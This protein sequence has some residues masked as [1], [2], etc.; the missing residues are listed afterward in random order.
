M[1]KTVVIGGWGLTGR[2]IVSFFE[3]EERERDLLVVEE[4]EEPSDLPS[5]VRYS[6]T[7]NSFLWDDAVC[8]ILSPGID[9]Q[10]DCFIE[11]KRRGIPVISDL[12]LWAQKIKEQKKT[13]CIVGITGS[14]GK[15]T[16][17][18]LV[19]Q[20]LEALGD[21]VGVGGNLGPP[22]LDLWHS[23][24][25]IYVLECSSFQ[26][27][28]TSSLAC[29][30]A[31][32]LN[33]S[34]D[35]LDRHHHMT[36]YQQAKQRIYHRAKIAVYPQDD[37][38]SS[39]NTE[40]FSGERR[41]F[42]AGTAI[43][44]MEQNKEAA[45]TIARAV[46]DIQQ[47]SCTPEIEACWQGV[48]DRFA[49]LDHRCVFLGLRKTCWWFNDSKATNLGAAQASIRSV[50]L[51]LK[52]QA[53]PKARVVW[54]A[55]GDA[56]GV[57]LSPLKEEES[58]LRACVVFGKDAALLQGVFPKASVV[59]NLQEAVWKA[60]VLAQPGDAVLLAPACS[61]LDMFR[62]YAQ[63]GEEFVRMVNEWTEQ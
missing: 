51:F 4:R 14:N 18:T 59:K 43:S 22:V 38:N 23:Q 47:R 52:Q 42:S 34:P 24:P 13:P 54:I 10:R 57:D 20:L 19:G 40:W 31:C 6:S 27:E 30:V 25:D 9:P 45:W 33:I 55:G 2:S 39:P 58:C 11:A 26:L 16:V 62:N 21:S 48:M 32:I 50:F 44:V 37:P 53:E 36:V 15:S 63:R 1:Q 46:L 49:G 5:S 17:T 61:S 29:S 41:C 56:K 35:H 60:A 28:N 12:E 8:V 7:F 3:K